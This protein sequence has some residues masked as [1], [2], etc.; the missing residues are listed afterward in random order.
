MRESVTQL[1]RKGKGSPAGLLQAEPAVGPQKTRLKGKQGA[2]RESCS[3]TTPCSTALVSP[4]GRL[5]LDELQIL[6]VVAGV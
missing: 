3:Q 1:Q 6:C 5:L 4:K 2:G